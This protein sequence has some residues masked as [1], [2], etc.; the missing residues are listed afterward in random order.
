MT[1]TKASIANEIQ[2][3]LD[4]SNK[5]SFE[6]IET[7]LEIMKKSLESGNDVIVPGLLTIINKKEML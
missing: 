6:L 2:N 7:L 4:V 1:A 3:Q 5:E